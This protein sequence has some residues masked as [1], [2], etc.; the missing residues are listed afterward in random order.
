MKL[1][2]QRAREAGEEDKLKAW[3][4]KRWNAKQ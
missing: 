2:E 1:L 3:F 4:K